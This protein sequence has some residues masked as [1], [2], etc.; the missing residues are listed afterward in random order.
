MVEYFMTQIEKNH[1]PR[2]GFKSRRPLRRRRSAHE[3][4][5]TPRRK[6]KPEADGELNPVFA[7]I[8]KPDTKPFKPDTFQL[9]AIEAI[10]H[11]D[12][13]VT[14]PTGAG[15]TWIAEK[16]IA[17]VLE[18]GGR[19]WY[20][21]PLKAL[22]N[23]KWIEFGGIFGE[24]R[25][26]IL[27]GDT[28][29]NADAPLIVGTTE[30]LRNQLYDSMHRGEMLDCDLVVL[31]EAHFLGDQ[32]RGVVWEEVMIYLPAR[33]NLLL[34][35]ATIGNADEIAGWLQS[36]R[37]KHCAVVEE[38][39]RPV[40]L[41]PLFLQ[42]SGRM[43][44]FLKGRSLHNK[45][46]SWM[47]RGGTTKRFSRLHPI[48][49]IIGVLRDMN[50][51]PAIF[52][53]KSRDECDT[54][55]SLC[56]KPPRRNDVH[57]FEE[58]LDEFF[59]ANPFLKE[60]RQLAALQQFRC[61]SHHAGQLPAWKFLVEQM[62]RK[63]LLE[64]VFATSTM[65]A[66]VN[67]PAR[68]VVLFNSDRF[69]G[70]EF[71]PLQA[72]EF[73]QMTGRAGRRG[74]DRIGFMVVYP[75][76][77]MDL[78]H[79]RSILARKPEKIESKIRNDFSMV[80]NLLLSHGPEEIRT[81]FEASFADYRPTKKKAARSGNLW[82]EFLRYLAFLEQEGY[83]D[84]KGRL[85]E[86]GLWASRLR[87]DQPLLVAECIRQKVFPTGDAALLAALVAPFVS[88]R[89]QD[90]YVRKREVPRKLLTAYYDVMNT[91][92]PLAQR[93]EDECF[94]VPSFPLWASL[95]IYDWALGYDW[96]LVTTALRIADGDLAMLV[97]RTADNLRQIASLRDT[98]PE[99][100]A[101]AEEARGF[102]MREP[103][104]SESL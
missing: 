44:P 43:T 60:H 15:K 19:C 7:K 1:K 83:V 93:M 91:I 75:G 67:F 46:I 71:V 42:P 14:A 47:E 94:E 89:S 17:R 4:D 90:V 40:D 57:E 20:A 99:I 52:F 33:V 5:K 11:S 97:S 38:T 30:I 27:T 104:V 50:L 77:F 36:I 85:T 35:S 56:R 69:N 68:T 39:R 13:L 58:E 62:M 18:Q 80:L 70:H 8:G 73:H 53:L 49:E 9:E 22:S 87:L 65:A 100:A 92:G 66:G 79:L 6:M 84:E 12:C 54:A 10:A 23:S 76:K 31:D 102:I 24:E 25:V 72:T 41:Y 2:G 98:H 88:D 82:K 16:A 32:D 37:N 101:L 55:L 74:L 28:K 95:A 59:A 48:D 63:G 78:F 34:L 103:V 81:I 21:S 45:V 29:E 3:T 51:L 26:G 86:S 96:T 64:A 61:A